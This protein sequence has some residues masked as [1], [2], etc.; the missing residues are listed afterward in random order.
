MK[1]A[2]S[3]ARKNVHKKVSTKS[4]NKKLH[5]LEKDVT[6]EELAEHV[7]SGLN[8]VTLM[9]NALNDANDDLKKA[10]EEI[11]ELKGEIDSDSKEDKATTESKKVE[12][13]DVTKT[14]EKEAAD[15]PEDKDE[16][17]KEKKEQEEGEDEDEDEEDSS[18]TVESK[19]DTPPETEGNAET[20]TTTTEEK[21]NDEAQTE[22]KSEEDK[23]KAAGDT[24]SKVEDE[25]DGSDNDDSTT[26]STTS[27]DK[28]DDDKET[29]AK[30]EEVKEEKEE[31]ASTNA[32]ESDELE[33]KDDT[34]TTTSTKEETA[35]SDSS[36]S[37]V[38]AET[39]SD[40][41]S[42]LKVDAEEDGD[43]DLDESMD[44][45]SIAL[46]EQVSN[47]I[48]D[49]MNGYATA[50]DNDLVGVGQKKYVASRFTGLVSQVNAPKVEKGG[51]ERDRKF[52]IG[53]NSNGGTSDVVPSSSG[54]DFHPQEPVKDELASKF[55]NPSK[56]VVTN[57]DGMTDVGDLPT[58][59]GENTKTPAVAGG[60]PP[61]GPSKENQDDED[62]VCMC[63]RQGAPRK[64]EAHERVKCKKHP[65][66]TPTPEPI[67]EGI[68]QCVTGTWP[69]KKGDTMDAGTTDTICIYFPAR[70]PPPP[71]LDP[72]VREF[73]DECYDDRNEFVAEGI[74]KRPYDEMLIQTGAFTTCDC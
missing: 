9:K 63:K 41:E 56:K 71:E 14:T 47:E 25:E 4:S 53:A 46:L 54:M 31:V 21:V 36:S 65:K 61:K 11:A 50:D 48:L 60:A 66:P 30:A 20:T 16:K 52:L 74:V 51:D 18:A 13:E 33:S 64:M 42:S 39:Q 62:S 59:T 7:T 72:E 6:I 8:E 2:K 73:P 29:T 22:T 15:V 35:P 32:D 5:N 26:T 44:L 58:G 57:S 69:G 37:D 17:E 28:V 19:K 70:L 45:E 3:N 10:L 43:E 34:D 1:K 49:D 24:E 38:V 40:D 23:T 12:T 68:R 27:T 67:P 55:V